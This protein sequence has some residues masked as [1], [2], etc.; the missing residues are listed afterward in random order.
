MAAHLDQKGDVLTTVEHGNFT[1]ET[2][3]TCTRED[4]NGDIHGGLEGPVLFSERG[5]RTSQ[6]AWKCNYTRMFSLLC[7]LEG[8]LAAYCA[9]VL[10][11]GLQYWA[12]SARD[13]R[14]PECL[15]ILN[16]GR[17]RAERFIAVVSLEKKC[18]YAQH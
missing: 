5:K 10:T 2:S 11:D 1:H 3:W 14:D 15:E 12:L 6:Q 4:I 9:C 8:I 7:D 16:S 13:I 18:A 17:S